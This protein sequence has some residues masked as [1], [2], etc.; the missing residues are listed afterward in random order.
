MHLNDSTDIIYTTV[1]RTSF[2]ARYLHVREQLGGPGRSYC[3]VG[4]EKWSHAGEQR[5][6]HIRLGRFLAADH[7]VRVLH[8]RAKWPRDT[9]HPHPTSA[10]SHRGDLDTS[11]SG[12]QIL[13]PS[14]SR[15][16]AWRPRP[17]RSGGRPFRTPEC[18]AGRAASRPESLAASCG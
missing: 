18:N 10:V 9:S 4:E 15:S 7:V 11:T 6:F 14:P 2:W 12:P 8:Q 1:T 13:A 16:R 3:R 17:L 5:L